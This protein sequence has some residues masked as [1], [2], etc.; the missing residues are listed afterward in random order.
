MFDRPDIWPAEAWL[1]A[2]TAVC[3][4]D[5]SKLD[6][7]S[8]T[9]RGGTFDT[10]PD[11][12]AADTLDRMSDGTHARVARRQEVRDCSGSVKFNSLRRER[13]ERKSTWS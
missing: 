5:S 7:M 11:D 8:S 10:L 9:A 2:G 1:V 3:A 6:A 12:K 4:I 13:S